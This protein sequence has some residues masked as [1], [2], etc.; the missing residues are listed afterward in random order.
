[1]TRRSACESGRDVLRATPLL[2]EE[3][4]T[5]HQERCREATFDGADGVVRQDETLRRSDHPV[6]GAKV[7]FAAFFLNAAATPPVPGGELPVPDSV[8]ATRPKSFDYIFAWHC[9]SGL[10]QPE[11]QQHVS[12][13]RGAA[14]RVAG[15]DKKHSSDSNGARCIDRAAVSRYSIYRGLHVISL[16]I[17][18]TIQA[19]YTP[20]QTSAMAQ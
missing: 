9:V 6:C 4:W 10:L 20:R 17:P 13:G 1:M 19:S 8:R 11:R 2:K 3:G 18:L 16:N 15:A 14:Y 7:G 5:R 12:A